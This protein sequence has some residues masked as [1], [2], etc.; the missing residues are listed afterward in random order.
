M[1]H[2][3][4]GCNLPC[5]RGYLCDRLIEYNEIYKSLFPEVK[6]RD[7]KQDALDL[8]DRLD[9]LSD[10][11]STELWRNFI[12]NRS[13]SRFTENRGKMNAYR[14]AASCI[15]RTMQTGKEPLAGIDHIPERR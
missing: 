6:I 9:K 11:W 4:I 10:Y 8:A 1:K 2:P 5:S 12:N 7:F 15:R 3:C 14:I 13:I